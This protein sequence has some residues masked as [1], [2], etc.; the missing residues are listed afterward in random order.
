MMDEIREVEVELNRLRDDADHQK[1]AA[2]ALKKENTLLRSRNDYLL[3]KLKEASYVYGEAGKR[4]LYFINN[5]VNPVVER[6]NKLESSS[7]KLGSED[8]ML[9]ESILSIKKSLNESLEKLSA[10]ITTLAEELNAR[11]EKLGQAIKGSVRKMQNGDA[12]MGERLAVAQAE[13]DKKLESLRVSLDRKAAGRISALDKD[14]NG[15]INML[16]E[17]NLIIGKDIEAIMKFEE[18]IGGLDGRLQETIANLSQTKLDMEKLEGRVKG[19]MS[20]KETDINEVMKRLSADVDKKVLTFSSDLR[21]IDEKNLGETRLSLEESQA[22][23][24]KQLEEANSARLSFERRVELKVR[25]AESGLKGDMGSG[26]KSVEDRLRILEKGIDSNAKFHKDSEKAI[27]D[28]ISSLDS[29][30]AAAN[31]EIAGLRELRG[32]LGELV[33]QAGSMR[34]RM[35]TTEAGVNENIESFKDRFERNRIIIKNELEKIDQRVKLISSELGKENAAII[36]RLKEESLAGLNSVRSRTDMMSKDVARLK[37]LFPDLK[38]LAGGLR[39]ADEADAALQSR[40]DAISQQVM[41]K[42]ERDDLQLKKQLDVLKS[43]IKSGMGAAESRMT[44][45]NVKAFSAARHNLKQDILA[46][47]EE[48]AALKAEVKGLHSLVAMVTGMQRSVA[49]M[50]KRIETFG[51]SMDKLA[52]STGSRLENDALKASK[53]MAGTAAKLKSDLKDMIAN[54]KEA[55]GR[56]SAG[57]DSRYDS[58]DKSVAG[59]G[60]SMEELGGHAGKNTQLSASNRKRLDQLD[61]RL[62]KVLSEIVSW[63]KEYKLELDRLLKEIEG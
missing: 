44:E 27:L 45:E 7:R 54:E 38:A 32:K 1:S 52:A 34:Q 8:K 28:K 2:H 47:R 63:K 55:F 42:S 40:I 50:E 33:K 30:L 62:Q 26:M 37:S 46:L 11:E 48:N 14:L 58:L 39:K 35:Q 16:R 18:D 29:G 61:K 10:R 20:K 17:R 49:G 25:K 12:G 21:Q 60:R 6:L 24:V 41:D 23:L 56:Q 36:S 4:L 43:E 19:S 53:D 3:N 57:L 13:I 51:S 59:V 22:S 5:Q 9:G 31:G 15:K